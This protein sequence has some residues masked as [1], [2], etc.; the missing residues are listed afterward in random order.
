MRVDYCINPLSAKKV[1]SESES[2]FML[3]RTS[4]SGF[5]VLYHFSNS[6]TG[7][8]LSDMRRNI[9]FGDFI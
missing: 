3:T 9:T 5:A 6:I 2:D 7:V 4:P 8:S 1:Q